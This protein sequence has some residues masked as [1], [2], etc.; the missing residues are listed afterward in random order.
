[1]FDSKLNGDDIFTECWEAVKHIVVLGGLYG[2]AIL[3]YNLGPT[4]WKLCDLEQVI[5]ESEINN[6]YE[7]LSAKH[8]ISN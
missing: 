8:R 4:T 3:V 2:H 7:V 1:M 5:H 6:T